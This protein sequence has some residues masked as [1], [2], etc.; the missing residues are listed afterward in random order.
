MAGKQ[1]GSGAGRGGVM[2]GRAGLGRRGVSGQ[3][4]AGK[5]VKPGLGRSATY[6][7]VLADT[8]CAFT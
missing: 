4:W 2:P 1:G 3:G 8:V 6:S 5:W 7:G